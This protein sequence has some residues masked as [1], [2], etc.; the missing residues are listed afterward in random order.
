MQIF[1]KQLQAV[2]LLLA[3]SALL[4]FLVE[5]EQ[6]RCFVQMWRYRWPQDLD[7]QFFYSELSVI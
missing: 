5:V 3:A 2:Q 1:E 6:I 4:L 7:E